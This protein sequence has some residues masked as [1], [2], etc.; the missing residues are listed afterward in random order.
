M[1][2]L[3][4]AR[5]RLAA[6]LLPVPAD[7]KRAWLNTDPMTARHWIH[8]LPLGM[9][10]SLG[11]F[12]LAPA[13]FTYSWSGAED[14]WAVIDGGDGFVTAHTGP[15]MVTVG[16]GFIPITDRAGDFVQVKAIANQRYARWTAMEAMIEAWWNPGQFGV[17]LMLNRPGTHRV[18]RGEPIAQMSVFPVEAAAL[19][20]VDAAQH[21]ETL[22][23]ARR[24]HRPE[25][26]G[27]RDYLQG[28]H[29]DGSKVEPHYRAWPKS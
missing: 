20:L 29:P 23:W 7:R 11:Y 22:D 27:D 12:I 28:R 13:T 18:E 24:R 17:V 1:T 19:E 3:R 25:Y 26:R 5:D 9:A 2:V 4:I 21:P 16:P 15:G 6:D 10:N 8:C 14:E